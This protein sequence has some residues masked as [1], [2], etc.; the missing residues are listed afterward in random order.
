MINKVEIGYIAAVLDAEGALCIGSKH[1]GTSYRPLVCVSQANATWLE[2]LKEVWGGEVYRLV[3]NRQGYALMWRW[4]VTGDAMVALL[5][6]VKPHLRLKK[7]QAELLL[8]LQARIG[9]IGRTFG[10]P[11]SMAELERR[12]NLYIQCRLLNRKGPRGDQLGLP[13]PSP[14]LQLLRGQ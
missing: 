4:N 14:Q 8:E 11:L 6:A 3:D 7:E 2:K 10:Q 5:K 9:R 1:G 13:E 12:R